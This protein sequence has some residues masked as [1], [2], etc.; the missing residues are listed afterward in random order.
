[1]GPRTSV[2]TPPPL[3][4]RGLGES[5]QHVYIIRHGDKYSSYPA[6]PG[7]KG[8]PCFDGDLMGDNP[9]LT[10]CGIK[11]AEHTAKWLQEH[12]K[13]AGGIQNIVV[14][15]YTRTLQTALP[16]AAALDKKLKVEYL[17]SEANQPEGPFREYNINAPAPTVPQLQEVHEHWDLDYGSLPIATPENNT[18]YVK[19]VVQAASVLRK[20]FPPSSGNLA[21]YTHATTS[22]S[23]AYGL[24][25]GNDAQLMAFVN[26]QDAIGPAGVIHV[27][28]SS[29]GQCVKV[30][31]TQNVAETVGCGKTEPFKCQFA[32]YPSWYW[33]NPLGKGPG[34]CH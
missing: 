9:P 10:E 30:E 15:P 8:Q 29:S 11:Q 24:C 2:A 33:S 20:R 28:L 27:T 16:L 14:S 13:S 21:V 23:V 32:D 5:V 12:S 19:R 22:F 6:C 17:I 7:E 25:Y 34:K 31:Q 4:L 1:M 26:G 18:L 3:R